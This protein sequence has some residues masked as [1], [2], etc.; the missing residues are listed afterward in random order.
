MDYVLSGLGFSVP[1]A[2]GFSFAP[3]PA[4]FSASSSTA[5]M[6]DSEGSAGQAFKAGLILVGSRIVSVEASCSASSLAFSGVLP[7]AATLAV[8]GCPC[9]GENSSGLGSSSV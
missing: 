9:L 2:L 7:G 3:F 6:V 1:E 4:C 5:T 8:T